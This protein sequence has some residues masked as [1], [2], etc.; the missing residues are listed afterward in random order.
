MAAYGEVHGFEGREL[1]ASTKAFGPCFCMRTINSLAVN[2]LGETRKIFDDA[3]GSKQAARLQ[4]G[5]HERIQ[6]RPRGVKRR[7]SAPAATAVPMM[8]TFSPYK[9]A[10]HKASTCCKWQA[11]MRAAVRICGTVLKMAGKSVKR[12]A[13]PPPSPSLGG[14]ANFL[15]AGERETLSTVYDNRIVR[16]QP[17]L[18]KRKANSAMIRTFQ[19]GETKS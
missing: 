15:P 12:S 3:R 18:N 5:K 6:I 1:D 14:Q 19:E 11:W 17:G 9:D 10:K 8:T 7:R 13:S 16:L 4:A 2:A